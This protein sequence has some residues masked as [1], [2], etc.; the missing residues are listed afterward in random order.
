M[1]LGIVAVL[2]DKQSG[3]LQVEVRAHDEPPAT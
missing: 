1:N 2:I 3:G